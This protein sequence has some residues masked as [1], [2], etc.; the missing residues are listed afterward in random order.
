M[1]TE[2]HIVKPTITAK[3]FKIKTDIIS[4]VQHSVQFDGL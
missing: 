2:L 3:K 1:G 4:M